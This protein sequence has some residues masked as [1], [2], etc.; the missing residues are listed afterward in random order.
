MMENF[1]KATI[2]INAI[3][4]IAIIV[5]LTLIAVIAFYQWFE[6]QSFAT[7]QATCAIKFSNYCI[8]WA[9]TGY[10]PNKPPYDWS[11]RSPVGCDSVKI[12]K[13]TSAK[14]CIGVGG[15]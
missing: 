8:E 4:L 13:P 10:D 9:K 14:D 6:G 11:T 2:A 1:S 12:Y 3:S 5:L 15:K 7:S